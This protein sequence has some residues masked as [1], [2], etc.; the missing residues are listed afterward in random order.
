[1]SGVELGL[2]IVGAVDVTL[3]S[4][5]APCFLAAAQLRVSPA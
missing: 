4:A 2:G 1:M 5:L 3:R